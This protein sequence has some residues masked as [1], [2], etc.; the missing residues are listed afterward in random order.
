MNDELKIRKK[1]QILTK[2]L[3]IKRLI[4]NTFI[5]GATKINYA[6]RVYDYKEVINLI[7][8]SLDFWLTEGPYAQKL[9]NKFKQYFKSEEFILVN[10]GSSANL[11]M[12][13]VLASLQLKK[14]LKHG[15]EIITPATTFPTTLTPIIQ[16]GFV[17]VFI[18]TEVGTYNINTKNLD[19]A[20]SKKTKAI[21]IAHTLGNP[22]DMASIMNV[23]KKYKLFVLEDNCDALG[24]VYNGKLTGTFGDMASLSFYPAHHMTMGEGGGININNPEMIR[25]NR[26]IRDWGRDCWCAPGHN[27]T[28]SKRFYGQWGK[29]PFGYDHKYVYSNLG[30]NLK[31]TDLQAAIGLA[32][33]D[34]IRDFIKRRRENF[35]ILYKG[36]QKYEDYLILPVWDKKANPSWFGF[37]ITVRKGIDRRTLIMFLEDAN[38]ETRLVFAGNI[39]RQPGFI[40][41]PHRIFGN[42][43]YTDEIMN[44][45]FFIG[46]YPGLTKQMIEFILQRFSRFFKNK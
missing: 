13:S 7:N 10:S 21:F 12:V 27:N 17:P 8:A 32:Q 9:A 40:N 41:I 16:N 43:K 18:D 3:I 29:L 24:A 23:A 38:I 25:I 30:Y 11:I 36:L 42:L 6:G 28:C 14:Y 1:I 4:K 31:I 37:P 15:D 22:C 26:S 46:V 35:Q 39:L 33:F 5:P 19:G 45:T 2:R 20:V 44:K 34:K